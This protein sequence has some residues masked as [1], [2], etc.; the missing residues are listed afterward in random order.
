MCVD[1]SNEVVLPEGD[2][3]KF[4]SNGYDQFFLKLVR[5]I[6]NTSKMISEEEKKEILK[7]IQ[8]SQ[9]EV[10]EA[11]KGI[12][13]GNFKLLGYN[14]KESLTKYQEIILKKTSGM[15]QMK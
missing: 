12:F 10:G 4:V 5:A 14:T 8:E 3:V 2:G 6:R 9:K 15:S 7:S 1:L 13:R 11:T